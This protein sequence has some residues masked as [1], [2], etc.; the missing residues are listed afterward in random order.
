[1]A[2][3]LSR[4][5]EM[6][7]TRPLAQEQRE[8]LAPSLHRTVMQSRPTATKEKRLSRVLSPSA[9]RPALAMTSA[10]LVPNSRRSPGSSAKNPTRWLVSSCSPEPN[11][12]AEKSRRPDRLPVLIRSDTS[13]E[14]PLSRIVKLDV[15]NCQPR[16]RE[17][18]GF[19]SRSVRVL[20]VNWQASPQSLWDSPFVVRRLSSIWRT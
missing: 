2:R 9:S 11:W 7:N 4:Q 12:S 13:N 16:C 1:V 6:R 15:L 17:Q 18:S 3:E 20:V 8:V 10:G 19:S 14:S 5:A